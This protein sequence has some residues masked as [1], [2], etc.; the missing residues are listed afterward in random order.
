MGSDCPDPERRPSAPSG[1]S[2]GAAAHPEWLPLAMANHGVALELG[3][4]LQSHWRALAGTSCDRELLGVEARAWLSS[5]HSEL[6][7]LIP[8]PGATVRQTLETAW[9]PTPP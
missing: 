9:G 2:A 1:P 4:D 5:L 3:A 8:F 7:P 6:Q